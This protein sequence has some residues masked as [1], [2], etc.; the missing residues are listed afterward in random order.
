MSHRSAEGIAGHR[1]DRRIQSGAVVG[2]G[3]GILLAILPSLLF[4]ELYSGGTGGLPLGSATLRGSGLLL[5]AGALLFLVSFWLYRWG[6]SGWRQRDPRFAV[7]IALCFVGTIGALA[8]VGCGIAIYSSPTAIETCLH[9]RPTQWSS[10]LIGLSPLGALTTIVGILGG[11]LGGIGLVVGLALVA[12][13]VRS[14]ALG[15]AS[16]VYGTLWTLGALTIVGG[17][18]PVGTA[19]ALLLLLPV[20]AIL[21]PLLTLVGATGAILA[22][23]PPRAS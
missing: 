10:C 5:I 21:A 15:V 7:P 18:L 17:D 16:A 8:V 22:S 1:G 6:F 23:A 14:T 2:L 4:T 9:G 3:A 20:V 19:R 13:W 11:V 12:R